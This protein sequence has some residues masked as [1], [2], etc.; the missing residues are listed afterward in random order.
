[1]K[2]EE[3]INIDKMYYINI[4]LKKKLYESTEYND[5]ILMLKQEHI[6]KKKQIYFKYTES[7]IIR[8]I[9]ESLLI[10]YESVVKFDFDY[11]TRIFE[12]VYGIYKQDIN[13]FFWGKLSL[14]SP[15]LNKGMRNSSLYIYKF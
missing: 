11:L 3:E 4:F 8:D 12:K 1:M 7:C 9:I 14:E 15:E 13:K 5:R 2:I 6:Y 10:K